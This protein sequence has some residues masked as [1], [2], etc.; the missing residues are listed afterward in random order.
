MGDLDGARGRRRR[1]R[2]HGDRP[3]V[4][5]DRETGVGEPPAIRRERD[6][7]GVESGGE[8]KG[9]TAR[10]ASGHRL[11]EDVARPIAVGDVVDPAAVGR[12]GR[13][14][15]DR[16]AVADRHDPAVATPARSRPGWA[17]RCRTAG[18]S[19]SAIALPEEQARYS[20]SGLQAQP[21]ASNTRAMP[22]ELAAGLPDEDRV[23]H[24]VGDP[25]AVGRPGRR[26]HRP[27]PARRHLGRLRAARGGHAH[28][29]APLE[30]QHP[31]AVGR[32]AG[33]GLDLR[34]VVGERDAAAAGHRPDED[35]HAEP[36]CR[37]R[38][39]RSCRRARSPAAPRCP[40][41]QVTLTDW[42]KLIGSAAGV[43]RGARRGSS[44]RPASAAAPAAS[45]SHRRQGEAAVA[46]AGARG[47]RC[48]GRSARR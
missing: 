32:P 18:P 17:R 37:W 40:G 19:V 45:G 31:A 5:L 35:P 14:Q 43:R 46:V 8:P 2:R 44:P 29:P 6:G 28:D 27:A 22:C 11:G 12:P 10:L 48:G 20:A 24:D 36:T 16:E 30:E 38:R 1:V 4:A 9:R 23:A 42:P 25:P 3:G 15:V 34:G 39:R 26:D 41:S 13:A 7:V 33:M 21:C 47:H